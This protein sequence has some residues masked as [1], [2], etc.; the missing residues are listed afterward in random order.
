[1]TD[2]FWRVTGNEIVGGDLE[3][4]EWKIDNQAWVSTDLDSVLQFTFSRSTAGNQYLSAVQVP[5]KLE[6]KPECMYSS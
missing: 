2:R 4:Y 5:L 6:F 3:G 1:V